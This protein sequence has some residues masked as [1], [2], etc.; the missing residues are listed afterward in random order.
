MGFVAIDVMWFE[1]SAARSHRREGVQGRQEIRLGGIC[2]PSRVGCALFLHVHIYTNVYRRYL[3]WQRI[4][5]S[6]CSFL[7]TLR[8]MAQ[9][10][11]PQR[12]YEIRSLDSGDNYIELGIRVNGYRFAINI[13][14]DN[15][16]DSPISLGCFRKILHQLASGQNDDSEVWD[17]AEQIADI[18]LPEFERLA[19][20][21]FH[22]GKL[23]LADISAR[24][25]FECEFRVL[26]ENTH[27]VNVKPRVT[28]PE[29]FDE[30]DVR[31]I[32]SDFPV[33]SPSEV[34]VPYSD[35]RYIY[36]IIPRRVIVNG[37]K[38]FYKTSWSP[39]DPIEEIENYVKIKSSSLPTEEFYISR[40]FG[41]VADSHGQTK[42]LLYE[43]IETFD[44]GTLRS[45]ISSDTP[46]TTRQKWADQIKGTLAKLH[47]MGVV[48]GN[49]KPDN[50]LIDKDG[51]AIITDLEGGTTRGWVDR[52]VG[53]TVQGD[54]QG[55]ER[56]MDFILNGDSPSRIE[57]ASDAGY[58]Q[59]FDEE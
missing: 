56:L 32:Q 1:K 29:P 39:F 6:S 48:W 23:T 34:E 36:D 54:M 5:K 30:W 18:F 42:G 4:F 31:K 43:V 22:S 45:A 26:N 52:E 55:M 12:P 10:D 57:A 14:P 11:L 59:D 50:V 49:V 47:G 19:P 28:Q 41:I 3:K 17:Y 38:L 51:N 15:F 16:S 20:P 46:T 40:L 13:S 25:V 53:G 7:V 8:I 37:Q 27:A 58:N 21:A 2:V 9:D 44:H 35:G 33:L 24:G